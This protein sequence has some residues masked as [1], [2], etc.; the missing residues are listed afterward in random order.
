LYSQYGKLCGDVLENPKIELP[1]DLAKHHCVYN[2]WKQ[3]Q[4]VEETSALLHVLQPHSQYL[5]YRNKEVS[6][7]E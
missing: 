7:H 5:R 1:R 6:I 2:E 3:N 4:D